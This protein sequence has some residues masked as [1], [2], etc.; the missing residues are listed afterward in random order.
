MLQKLKTKNKQR[1]KYYSWKPTFDF[2]GEITTGDFL[3][4]PPEGF[5]DFDR[6]LSFFAIG[7]SPASLFLFVPEVESTSIFS[8]VELFLEADSGCKAVPLWLCNSWVGV[9]VLDLVLFLG[10]FSRDFFFDGVPSLCFFDG[11]EGL[12]EE[13]VLGLGDFLPTEGLLLLSGASSCW[14]F[15]DKFAFVSPWSFLI[16]HL[17]WPA[18]DDEG[19]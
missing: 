11:V 3:K 12:E 18:S 10:L 16:V 9:V 6:P 2:K 19:F 17:Y 8:V 4:S 14:K 15:N 5:G 1:T 13:G 7:G